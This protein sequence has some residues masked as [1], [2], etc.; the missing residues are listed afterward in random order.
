MK[1]RALEYLIKDPLLHICIGC[2]SKF[3]YA[4]ER[5]GDY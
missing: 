1:S 2:F 5:R 4:T 3:N